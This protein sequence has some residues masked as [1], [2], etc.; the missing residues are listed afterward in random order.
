MR[1]HVEVLFT[2]DATGRMRSVNE[3]GGTAAPQFFL[4]RTTEGNEWRFRHDVSTDLVQALEVLCMD[5]PVSED[6]ALP[7]H[8]STAYTRLLAQ[9]APIQ[10]L[11]TGP[12]YRF[13]AELPAAAGA[14]LV[15]SKNADVLRPHFEDWLGD[16]SQNQPFLALMRDGQAVSVCCSVRMTGEAYEVGVETQ[17]DFRGRGYAAQLISAWAK[18]VRRIDRIPLFSTSWQNTASQAVAEK[19]GLVRY[20]VDLHIT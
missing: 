15:T 7:P 20:G 19:L 6:I 9:Q 14:V 17:Q 18:A 16:I 13:P 12:A 10:N 11:W 8:S 5:E 3:P 1:I 4:G 2:H